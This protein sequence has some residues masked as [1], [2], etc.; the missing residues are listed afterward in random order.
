MND[1]NR[2]WLVSPPVQSVCDAERD[3]ARRAK[4]VLEGLQNLADKLGHFY[5]EVGW[6]NRGRVEDGGCIEWTDGKFVTSRWV[7]EPE[8]RD[9]TRVDTQH[10]TLLEALEALMEEK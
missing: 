6:D 5:M 9:P 3:L 4:N 10:D 2:N 8:W 7:Q 1:M